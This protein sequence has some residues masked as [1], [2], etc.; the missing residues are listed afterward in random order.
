MTQQVKDLVTLVVALL[1]LS[2]GV[3]AL[4]M[5]AVAALN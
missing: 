5:G 1:L 2:I 3:W 4:H